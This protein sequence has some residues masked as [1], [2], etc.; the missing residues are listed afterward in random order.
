[1]GR[2]I[3]L[4]LA[5]RGLRKDELRYVVGYDEAVARANRAEMERD[6]LK[7]R[8]ARHEDLLASV[9]LY[10]RW[11]DVTRS[12]TTEQ[13]ELFADSIE[14]HFIRVHGPDG[15]DPCALMAGLP[16]Y[17]R[18]WWRPEAALDQSEVTP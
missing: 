11:R 15:E 2:L 16:S 12:L 4:R 17:A 14:R 10:I 5:L 1:M 7:A 18:R 8:I 13:K 9:A 6:R 3:A